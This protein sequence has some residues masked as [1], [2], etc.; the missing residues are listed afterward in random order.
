MNKK[1]SLRIIGLLTA[2]IFLFGC[3]PNMQL[4]LK[5]NEEDNA[6]KKEIIT[7]HKRFDLLLKDIKH[8]KLKLGISKKEVFS[9]YGQPVLESVSDDQEMLVRLLYRYPTKFFG[10]TKVYLYFDAN[11]K[12][13]KWELIERIPGAQNAR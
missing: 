3:S 13:V 9:R 11:E 10:S 4:L 8:A 1:N 2:V 5:V 7:A 12:L 6:L